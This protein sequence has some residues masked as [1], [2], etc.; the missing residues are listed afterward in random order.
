MVVLSV[1]PLGI[2]LLSPGL[3]SAQTLFGPKQY[4]LTTTAPQTVTNLVSTTAGPAHLHVT[5]G[6]ADGSARLR[7][8]SITLNGL[9][10]VSPQDVGPDVALVDRPVTLLSTNVLTVTLSGPVNGTLQVTLERRS[11][12][13]TSVTPGSGRQ[14]ETLTVT[15]V[16]SNT[17]FAQGSTQL[18]AG[19]GVSVGGAPPGEVGP[20]T[21]QDATHLT[22]TLT[23]LPTTVLGPRTLLARTNGERAALFPGL[24]ILAGTPA[25]AGTT[26]TT[27]AGSGSPGSTDGAATTAQFRFPFDVAARP[28]GSAVVADTGNSTLRQVAPDGTVATISL[29]VSLLLPAGVT[30]DPAGRTVVADTARCAIRT[31]NTDGTVTAIGS[32][33]SCAF[34]DGPSGTA[35]FKFPRDVVADAGGNLYVADTGNFRVRKID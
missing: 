25:L 23:I 18:S 12:S 35:R 11:A 7:H 29:P 26:V 4:T 31:V 15:I 10:V 6:A 16:G 5:N 33:G 28:D 22:A 21:V 14:G 13:L 17:H 8:A 1:L 2:C 27:L 32:A 30:L 19:P 9:E 24:T 20:V 34:A 3:T